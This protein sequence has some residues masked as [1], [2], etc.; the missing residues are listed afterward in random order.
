M[1]N[2]YDRVTYPA[3]VDKYYSDHE[4][5][6]KEIEYDQYLEEMD[7]LEISEEVYEEKEL[8]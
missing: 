1:K 6:L 2:R 7:K 3:F 5:T 4:M 8:Q